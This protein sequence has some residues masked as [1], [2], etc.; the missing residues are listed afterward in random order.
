MLPNSPEW[1]YCWLGLNK[2]GAVQTA[3]NI[4]LKGP[5]LHYILSHSDAKG[6]VINESFYPVLDGIRS[7]LP[8]LAHVIVVGAGEHE[9]NQDHVIQYQTW[10]K[11]SSDELQPVSISEEDPAILIYTSGTTGN[12]KGVLNSHGCWVL[13]GECTAYMSGVSLQDRIITPNPLFHVMAQCYAVMSS[14]AANASLVLLEKFSRSKLIEQTRRYGGSI[15]ILAAAATPMLWSR[16]PQDDDGDNPVRVMQAGYVPSDYYD[17]FENRFRLKIQTAYSLTETTIAVMAPRE[18]TRPRKKTPGV[19]IVTEHPDLTF[20]NEVKIVDETGAEVPRGQHGQFIVKNSAVMIGYYKDP[21]KTAE[22]KKD[23]WIYTGDVGYQDEDGY[24][25]FV[26]R[27][28]DVLRRKGELFAPAEIESVIDT[29]P[30]VEDSAVI[31]LPSDLG[32]G[33]EEVKAYVLPKSEESISAQEII[34]WCSQRL[35]DFKVPRYIEFRTEFPRTPTSKIQKN[36]LKAEKKDPTEGCYD[37][38][39][40]GQ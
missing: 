20:Q 12:P 35:A 26:G 30:K 29:H 27:S 9:S 11:G 22:T 24:F 21:E 8:R 15:L 40:E 32:P 19:G 33:E 34:E 7:S 17:D 6:I 23:G 18:G 39:K 25:F 10:L 28:K 2:I 37:R 3:V 16:S 36:I 4:K 38:E 13:T 1:L 31:G 5:E 14:L